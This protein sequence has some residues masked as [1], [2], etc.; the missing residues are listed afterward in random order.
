MKVRFQRE[1]SEHVFEWLKLIMAVNQL[2]K[3]PCQ[4]EVLTNRASLGWAQGCI[5]LSFPLSRNVKRWEEFQRSL[6]WGSPSIP[7][8]RRRLAVSLGL[9]S[10]RSIHLLKS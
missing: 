3:V 9:P 10:F 2:C 1:Y 7:R 5:L 4:R 8:T 6:V